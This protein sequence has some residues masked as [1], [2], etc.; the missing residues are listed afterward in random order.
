MRYRYADDTIV[1]PTHKYSVA[2]STASKI[3]KY[4]LYPVLARL[5]D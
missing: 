4:R 5:D 3:I 1:V 2:K